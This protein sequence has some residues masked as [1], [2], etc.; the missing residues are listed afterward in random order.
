MTKR[1]NGLF[2]LISVLPVIA[3]FFCYSQLRSN[4]NTQV[5]GSHGMTI[6][7]SSFVFL[8]IG[9]SAL[10]YYISDYVAFKLAM[11]NFGVSQ[12]V[13]RSLINTAFSL[14][15]ILLILSNR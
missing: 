14:L 6:S 10:S 13:S 7:K 4:A 9:L 15:S 3:L 2:I 5:F 11:V 1:N 12:S 8:I